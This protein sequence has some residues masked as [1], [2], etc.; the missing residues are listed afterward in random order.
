MTREDFTPCSED[1]VMEEGEVFRGAG[2]GETRKVIKTGHAVDIPKRSLIG[3][4][5][6][7]LEYA[8]PEIKGMSGEKAEKF[9]DKRVPEWATKKGTNV[10]T[11]FSNARGYAESK[12]GVVLAFDMGKV[13]ETFSPSSVHIQVKNPS[14]LELVGYCDI[15]EEKKCRK[16]KKLEEVV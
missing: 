12:D 15:D 7:V 2:S 6:E 3:N 4:D 5:W 8:Y 16:K 1:E 13:E 10:T 9:L 11:S 14:R